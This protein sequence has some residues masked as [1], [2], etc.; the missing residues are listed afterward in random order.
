MLICLGVFASKAFA[1]VELREL[2]GIVKSTPSEEMQKHFG[3]YAS[4]LFREGYMSSG[5][6]MR[7]ISGGISGTGFVVKHNGQHYFLTNNHVIGHSDSVTVE[8]Q[9]DTETKEFRCRV[10]VRNRDL[11]LALIEL[12]AEKKHA[13][14]LTFQ[15]TTPRD[16]S[17]VWSAGFPGLLGTTPTWQLGQGVISNRSVR[18]PEFSN[19]S[20]TH[21]IQHTAQVDRGNSGGPLL[22]R[23]A[24][25]PS[26]YDVIGINTWKDFRRESANLTVPAENIV[27]FLESLSA[28]PTTD[29]DKIKASEHMMVFAS[30]VRSRTTSYKDILPFVSE[31]YMLSVPAANF[32]T[33]FRSAS[34]DARASAIE[35]FRNV[36][37]IEGIRIIIADAIWQK[38]TNLLSF[39]NLIATGSRAPITTFFSERG[40][41]VQSRW[42]YENGNLVMIDFGGL[43]IRHQRE[44][45]SL[46][47]EPDR[48][49]ALATTFPI[50]E[51]QETNYEFT[52]SWFHNQY[53]GLSQ[54]IRVSRISVPIRIDGK[55]GDTLRVQESGSFG[56]TLA[57]PFVQYPIPFSRFFLIPYVQVPLSMNLGSITSISASAEVGARL[58]LSFR[59][60]RYLYVGTFYRMN[61]HRAV[62]RDLEGSDPGFR[63]HAIGV[64]LGFNY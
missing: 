32:I 16:G 34:A 64:T 12:P 38:R 9:L 6:Y 31:N 7:A 60:N 53:L 10:L 43:P 1:Q 3:D 29:F 52:W 57:A 59:N 63:T 54:A 58:A 15:T 11:D 51:W 26:G 40:R 27:K 2:V 5:R 13:R 49:F 24:Q 62:M 47:Y 45:V 36:E 55:T 33:M 50:G 37:P 39:E 20:I 25:S 41:P 14:A 46:Q 56:L 28:A 19:A 22:V 17:E 44:G 4:L 30:I 23:N 61:F 42:R 21:V 48:G 18:H 8:F 35:Q